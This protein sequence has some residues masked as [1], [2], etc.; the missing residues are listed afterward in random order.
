M[1]LTEV[2]PRSTEQTLLLKVQGSTPDWRNGAIT[3]NYLAASQTVRIDT[4]QPSNLGPFDGWR[5]FAPLP[6]T[7]R[8]GDRFAA[9]GW[10]DGTV[11]VYKN[12]ALVGRVDTTGASLAKN[13]PVTASGNGT[14]FVNK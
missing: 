11:R 3:V 1:T 7:F 6:V 4:F 5:D 12:G 10:A 14:F 13:T 8:D 9:W 2:D